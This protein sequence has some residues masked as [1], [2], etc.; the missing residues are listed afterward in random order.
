MIVS[1]KEVIDNL[2]ALCTAHKQINS[3]YHVSSDLVEAYKENEIVHTT[4]LS[5]I[6]TAAI[7]PTDITISLQLAVVDK[8]LKNDENALEIESNTLQILG[9]LVNYMDINVAWQY[10]S[11]VSP[12][13]VTKLVDRNLDVVDGWMATIQLKLMKDNGVCDVPIV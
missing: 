10:S 3:Y 6:K 1:I 9:D 11:V 12:P 13:S 8:T 5:M 2:T 4:A 7:N